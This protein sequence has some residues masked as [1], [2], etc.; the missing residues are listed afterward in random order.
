MYDLQQHGFIV[1]KWDVPTNVRAFC[2][3]KCMAGESTGAYSSFNLAMHVG[4]EPSAVQANREM[5]LQWLSQSVPNTTPRLHVSWLNQTH[6]THSFCLSRSKADTLLFSQRDHTDA[7]SADASF[8][9]E[10][11]L[12]CAVMTADCIPILLSDKSGRWV[13]A[14]HSGWRGLAKGVIEETIANIRC[15]YPD[16]F[17]VEQ[18]VAWLGPSISDNVFEVGRD[19]LNAFS[20]YRD[21]FSTTSKP[22]KYLANL[23]N[24]AKRKLT[25]IGVPLTQITGGDYCTYSDVER[26][27]SYRR[28]GVTGRIVSGVFL[29]DT[30]NSN[31][32]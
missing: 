2:T 13:A 16:L 5:L 20:D 4:D 12:V 28:E 18:T 14:I 32:K 3:T 29:T 10:L 27:Y 31:E 9:K 7:G 19:V 8:T 1:P 30:I 22:D 25:G 26:F 23:Y 11:G 15:V 21:C 24:I 17:Q 6:S